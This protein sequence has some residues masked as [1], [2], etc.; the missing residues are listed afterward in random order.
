MVISLS[1]DGHL[2]GDAQRHATVV[3]DVVKLPRA[4]PHHAPRGER[5]FSPDSDV[6]VPFEP[7]RSLS[8]RLAYIIR[9]TSAYQTGAHATLGQ[10]AEKSRQYRCRIR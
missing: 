9:Y 10:S 7:C 2:G 4:L 1:I 3:P 8:R 6:A 5:H